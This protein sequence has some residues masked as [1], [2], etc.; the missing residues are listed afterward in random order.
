MI[1]VSIITPVYNGEKFVG[2]CIESVQGQKGLCVEHI[3][4]DG[5]SDDRTVAIAQSYANTRVISERD[6]G[7]YDAINKGID[8][9]QGEI[10]GILNCDDC[11]HDEYTLSMIYGAIQRDEVDGVFG[12]IREVDSTG[13]FLREVYSM[14]VNYFWFLR[15]QHGTMIAHPTVYLRRAVFTDLRYRTDF[16]YVSDYVFLLNLLQSNFRLRR[17]KATIVD[18]AVRNDSISGLGLI[19]AEKAA[20]FQE[21]GFCPRRPSNML[22]FLLVWVLFKLMCTA[23]RLARRSNM[24]QSWL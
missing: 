19:A 17:L 22:A 10:I 15:A 2:R 21:I 18:F 9:A 14:N 12:D 6:H 7:M 8:L 13:L 11:L 3:V 23:R 5:G 16:R 4:V 20:Y 1:H 24:R